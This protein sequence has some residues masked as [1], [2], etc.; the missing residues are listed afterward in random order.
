MGTVRTFVAPI[1]LLAALLVCGA[2]GHQRSIL[3]TDVASY[4][5]V[6]GTTRSAP[7]LTPD[8]QAPILSAD[9]VS[10]GP[11]GPFAGPVRLTNGDTEAGPL[12]SV[13][14]EPAPFANAFTDPALFGDDSADPW[15][16]CPSRMQS[17][18]IETGCKLGADFENYFSWITMRDL[19]LGVGLGAVAANTSL[20]QNFQD[21]YQNDVGTTGSDKV[22]DFWKTFGERRIFF[23]AFAGLA[24]A[25]TLCQDFPGGGPVADFGGRTT[26]AYLIGGPPLL[27]MQYALG[28]SR[29]M[30]PP[31]DS[32]WKPYDDNNGVSGHAFVGAVPFI[33]A[34]KMTEDPYLKGGLYFFSSLTAWSRVNDDRHY[35]SQ[36]WLGW[37]MAYLTCRAI[38]QTEYDD[39][40]LT[41][42]PISTPEMI[43]MGVIYER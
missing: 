12:A 3:R 40:N 32:H 7:R 1:A 15:D 8:V 19:M 4:N 17:L 20:D 26:R 42:T 28:A 30:E 34:A 38:D 10:A 37:W 21:W 29:P 24:V 22:A 35:L 13:V 5:R 2:C 39:R 36:A 33:T 16:E 27:L 31:H 11:G 25:G 18:W 9:P 6:A 14:A 41:F 23:P 43:G